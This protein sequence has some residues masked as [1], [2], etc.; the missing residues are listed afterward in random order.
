MKAI[1]CLAPRANAE[2]R[3]DSKI[4]REHRRPSTIDWEAE[5]SADWFASR[6]SI[7]SALARILAALASL[8]RAFE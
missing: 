6:L 4:E 1:D 7:P 3:A 2:S 8:G 5:A